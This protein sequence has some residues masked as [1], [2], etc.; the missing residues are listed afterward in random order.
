MKFIF[1]LDGTITSE[2]TLPLIARAFSIEK[3]IADLT[4]ETIRG[5]V[6]FI[7]SFIQRVHLLKNLPVDQVADLLF[8][9][10]INENICAFI[11]KNSDD[12]LIATGNLDCWVEKLVAKIGCKFFSSKA[13]VV[14]NK[15][16][17]LDVILKKETIV[18]Q[19][20]AENEKVVFI[21]DGNNDAEAMRKADISIAVGIIHPPAKSIIPFSDYLIFNEKPLCRQLNQLL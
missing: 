15:I 10:G 18:S 17:K 14:E 2:E 5:N 1:D 11:N 21:G 16:V 9:V 3:E 20:Q 6:P 8:N 4:K 13:S 19:F 7:E 12:C